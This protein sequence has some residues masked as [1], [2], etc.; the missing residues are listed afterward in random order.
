M[1]GLPVNCRVGSLEKGQGRYEPRIFVNCRVG[2]LEKQAQRHLQLVGV[3]CRVGS[4]EKRRAVSTD[5]R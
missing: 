4:L 1:L 3:N 5:R 2:S